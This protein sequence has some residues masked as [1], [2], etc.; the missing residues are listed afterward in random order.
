VSSGSCSRECG[1]SQCRG[2]WGSDI[3]KTILECNLKGDLDVPVHVVGIREEAN[4]ERVDWRITPALVEEATS[5]IQVL[6]VGLI[7][8]ATEEVQI[9]DLKV[10]PEVAGGVPV[11][12]LSMLG[13]RLIICDPLPHVVLTQV[14]RIRSQELAGLGP[15]GLD[16]LRGVVQVDGE[17]VCLV[18]VLH[19]AE[20]VV[21]DIAEELNVGLDAPIVTVLVEC[22]VL[23]EHAAVPSAHLVVGDLRGVLDVFFLEHLGRLSE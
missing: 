4:A 20:Y 12:A 10:G 8:L 6:E 5:T 22:R 15:E 23:V 16:G 19:V 18:S 17:A 13:A 2:T 21:V 3:S 14:R 9:A 7:L 11:G 1:C